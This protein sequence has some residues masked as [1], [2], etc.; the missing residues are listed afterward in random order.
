MR[1]YSWAGAILRLTL[2]TIDECCRRILEREGGGRPAFVYMAGCLTTLMVWILEHNL[3]AQ[4]GRPE[5]SIPYQQWA[6]SKIIASNILENVLSDLLTTNALSY[7]LLHELNF[8]ANFEDPIQNMYEES[9]Y[10][11]HQS[12]NT[13]NLLSSVLGREAWGS[14]VH[15]SEDSY[16][17]IFPSTRDVRF[18]MDNGIP[19]SLWVTKIVSTHNFS[20]T[21]L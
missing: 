9:P 21:T 1:H 3:L 6:K 7:S 12:D 13:S 5:L 18:H 14:D 2:T 16:R 4:P 11:V 15:T 19:M 8:Q 17:N 10:H 20:L